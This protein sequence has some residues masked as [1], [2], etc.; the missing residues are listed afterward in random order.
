LTTVQ[1]ISNQV[2]QSAS[3]N[4]ILFTCSLINNQVSFPSNIL[5]SIGLAGTAFGANI[6]YEAK[7]K[8]EIQMKDGI[9]NNLV[10]SLLN[11][12]FQPLTQLDKNMLINLTISYPDE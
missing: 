6:N 3:V 4:T 7:I 5:D 11:E 12:N 10:L 9:Y 1:L 2:P 8:K